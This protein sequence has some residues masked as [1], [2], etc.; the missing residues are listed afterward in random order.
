MLWV[1]INLIFGVAILIPIAIIT[2]LLPFPVVSQFCFFV[3]DQLYRFCVRA[4]SFWMNKVVGIKVNVIGKRN[5]HPAPI[6]I[7]NHQ[8]WFDIPLI[9]DVITGQGPIV[10]F[11]I[12]RELALVPIIG[13]ICLALNFPRLNRSKKTDSRAADFSLIEKTSKKHGKQGALLIFPE[14]TRYTHA[15]SDRQQSPYHGLLKPKA[16]GMKIIQQHSAPDTP[17]IDITINYGDKLHTIWQCL[18]GSPR[19]INI[20]LEHF[21]LSELDN[22]EQWL[23]T[24]W[25]QKEEIL[26]QLV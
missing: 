6:V 9:Q 7:C 8:S 19:A 20:T 23:N 22:V 14:G 16:G 25:Q 2:W 18:H 10:R 24:R 12:K 3:V 4:D 21:T 11:L 1:M 13:W 5:T 15:K 26:K 17:L